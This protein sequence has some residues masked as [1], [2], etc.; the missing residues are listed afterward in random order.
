MAK[1]KA[2]EL[3][4]FNAKQIKMCTLNVEPQS[5]NELLN[6]FS[7]L[8]PTQLRRGLNLILQKRGELTDRLNNLQKVM[9]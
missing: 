5:I 4:S 7:M 2:A 8:E 9:E 1:R 3:E 6:V